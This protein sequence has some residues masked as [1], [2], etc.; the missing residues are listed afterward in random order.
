MWCS[1]CGAIDGVGGFKKNNPGCACCQTPFCCDGTPPSTID[2]E[3]TLVAGTGINTGRPWSCTDVSCANAWN[4]SGSPAT[5]TYVADSCSWGLVE[6]FD[7][8]CSDPSIPCFPGGRVWNYYI[9]TDGTNWSAWLKIFTTDPGGVPVEH[10]WY[11]HDYGPSRP[12]CLLLAQVL[13]AD[14]NTSCCDWSGAQVQIL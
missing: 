11:T 3:I 14:I 6:V 5:L 8:I 13:T 1:T 2:V 4:N 7:P 12:S 10:V 9:Q